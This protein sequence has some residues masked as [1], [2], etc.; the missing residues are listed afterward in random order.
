L[1]MT[2]KQLKLS[3]CCHYACLNDMPMHNAPKLVGCKS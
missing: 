3:V 1:L 2:N